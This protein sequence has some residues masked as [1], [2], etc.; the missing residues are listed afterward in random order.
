[1]QRFLMRTM[2]HQKL[3]VASPGPAR[4]AGGRLGASGREMARRE[5][6]GDGRTRD[7]LAGAKDNPEA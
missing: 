4:C 3:P 7:I 6:K 2:M 1:M 5:G